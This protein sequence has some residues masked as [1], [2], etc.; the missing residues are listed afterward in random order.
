MCQLLSVLIVAEVTGMLGLVK[1]NGSQIGVV[2]K[3][4]ME[5]WEEQDLQFDASEGIDG[6][7]KKP[8]CPV[9]KPMH[10]LQ[11]LLHDISMVVSVASN[12]AHLVQKE[13]ARKTG[14]T[15]WSDKAA[16]CDDLF[17]ECEEEYNLELELSTKNI[18]LPSIADLLAKEAAAGNL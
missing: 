1:T 5:R 3:F 18:V 17:K 14:E 16:A 6:M 11:R 9:A 13:R 12:T 2:G 4:L 15:V 7:S 10:L 8:L